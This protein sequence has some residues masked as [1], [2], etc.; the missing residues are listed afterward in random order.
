MQTT[1]TRL[2]NGF[3]GKDMSGASACTTVTALELDS[4]CKEGGIA[5]WSAYLRFFD[6]KGMPRP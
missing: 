3:S 5:A 2:T 6:W 1:V 4:L